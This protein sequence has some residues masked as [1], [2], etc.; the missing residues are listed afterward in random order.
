METPNKLPGARANVKNKRQNRK[1]PATAKPV[2]FHNQF[3]SEIGQR[4]VRDTSALDP[5]SVLD[6]L[7]R[8]ASEPNLRT[9]AGITAPEQTTTIQH[10]RVNNSE[11]SSE[12]SKYDVRELSN[13][14]SKPKKMPKY[15]GITFKLDHFAALAAL[16]SL[17]E[18][19]GRISHMGILDPSYS[20]FMNQARDAALY[21][22]I[23]NKIAVVGGNPLCGLG[24]V[25]SLLTE[26]GKFRKK[27]GLGI[28]FLGASGDFVEYAREQKGWVSMRFGAERALNPM[29][30]KVIKEEEGKRIVKQCKQLLDPKRG[31]M[32]V[33][34]YA[35]W[36]KQDLGLQAQLVE[37]YETWRK[38]RNSNGKPQAYMTVFDPFA[39][40][41]LMVY[42]YTSSSDGKPNGFAALRRMSGGYHI[43]P[44]CANPDA[45]RGTS[46]LLIF[47]ALALLNR[48]EVP[49]LGLG[50]E[51][52]HSITDIHGLGPSMARITQSAYQRTFSRLPIS[53]KKG[54]HD[55][56]HP[57]EALDAGLYIIYPGGRPTLRHS[58]A[59]MH[60]A[61]V[62][63]RE[64][65]MTEIKDMFKTF[66]VTGL[67]NDI[68]STQQERKVSCERSNE[69]EISN[70]KAPPLYGGIYN[71][72]QVSLIFGIGSNQAVP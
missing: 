29:T 38:S 57:D 44:Y 62:C 51:P 23:K 1:K 15:D 27:H 46:D 13:D 39:L 40:P 35:P 66:T 54:F 41:H 6:R 30:N 67:K 24:R 7:S 12:L 45:P 37:V 43:D 36:Q 65:V 26:F 70:T 21:Y 34:I 48:A 20:F 31:G 19:H 42:I 11:T 69:P 14:K 59:T 60:F 56:W 32:R 3:S 61:N 49:Y 68:A 17:I 64:I 33:D 71:A 53:G 47:A 2:L 10:P 63:V 22:K 55:K 18:K 4:L 25:P 52:A 5:V 28:A 50:F 8:S 58:L 9:S 16:N 72:S